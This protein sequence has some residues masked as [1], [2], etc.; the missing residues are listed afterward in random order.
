MNRAE[1]MAAPRLTDGAY[2]GSKGYDVHSEYFSQYV[3]S[4]MVETLLQ[5][6]GSAQ[7][8]ASRDVHLNDIALK[9]WDDLPMT[10]HIADVAR[11]LGDIPSL[12]SKVCAYKAAARMWLKENGG[13]AMWRVR[14][15]YPQIGAGS[16]HWIY[17]YAIG[18]DEAS[19][20]VAF[21]A[22]NPGTVRHEI[23]AMERIAA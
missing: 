17:S 18:G 13:L 10:R 16:V 11:A 12:S 9:L 23:I 7:L 22:I 5:R 4:W 14:Y 8:L 6:I 2:D 1:Y 3:N 20:L 21:R 19:A 15:Q